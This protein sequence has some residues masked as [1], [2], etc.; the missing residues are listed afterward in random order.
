MRRLSRARK[1]PRFEYI[2]PPCGGRLVEHYAGSNVAHLVC[3]KC[4]R[5]AGICFEVHIPDPVIPGQIT[6]EELLDDS[7]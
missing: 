4:E 5:I 3:E 2:C 7:A 6:I 1:P